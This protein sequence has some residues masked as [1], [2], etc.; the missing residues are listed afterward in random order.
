[1]RNDKNSFQLSF[2]PFSLSLK[3]FPVA[4]SS[5]CLLMLSLDRYATVKHSRFT[6]LRQR[7]YVPSVLAIAAWLGSSVL[8]LP[9]LF[10]YSI[11]DNIDE[12][13]NASSSVL[14]RA[15]GH[16]L[17]S[18]STFILQNDSLIN[19]RRL[20][21]SNYGADEWH[22]IFIISYV[23]IAF[24]VPCLGIIFNHLGEHLLFAI[25]LIIFTF[26]PFPL[27]GVRRKLCALSLTARAQHGELPLP[28]P[29]ILRR[30]THMILVTG[31]TPNGL[32]NV[33]ETSN[34]DFLSPLKSSNSN[35]RQQSAGSEN[36]INRLNNRRFNGASNDRN[37]GGGEGGSSSTRIQMN[38]T[39]GLTGTD[40]E[41]RKLMETKFQASPR[42]PK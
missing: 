40:D 22:L 14:R 21:I 36:G 18:S 30:P 38:R 13:V 6:H 27:P 32:N 4:A 39:C 5:L 8:C 10:A 41:S 34:D 28:M 15:S 11:A 24:V 12:S 33:Q 31:M 7:H 29:T 3:T 20:C 1:M 26:P 9:F 35:S 42:I 19:G 25:I 16:Q 2:L 17:N 37:G 23:G